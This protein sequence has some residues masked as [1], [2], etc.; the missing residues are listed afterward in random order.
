MG[1]VLHITNKYRVPNY[2]AKNLG[3]YITQGTLHFSFISKN[4]RRFQSE[5][6]LEPTITSTMDLF[7]KIVDG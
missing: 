4:N 1:Q 2:A 7:A 6:C 3:R 5:V